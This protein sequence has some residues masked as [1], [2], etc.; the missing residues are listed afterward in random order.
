MPGSDI[1]RFVS[2][3]GQIVDLGAASKLDKATRWMWIPDLRMA[4][5]IISASASLLAACTVR[6]AYAIREAIARGDSPGVDDPD[7]T[8]TLVTGSYETNQPQ[9]SRRSSSRR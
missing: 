1:N 9:R 8:T 4:A 7:R 5:S 2:G 6:A 3:P